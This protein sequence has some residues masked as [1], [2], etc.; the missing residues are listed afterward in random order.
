MLYSCLLFR[1][2]LCEQHDIWWFITCLYK[3][4]RCAGQR[5]PEEEIRGEGYRLI[6]DDLSSID[7]LK[8]KIIL[9]VQGTFAD[10]D[11]GIGQ[12]EPIWQKTYII[13][14]TLL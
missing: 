4:S 11:L 5:Q 6:E 7:W 13:T 8:L 12:Q 1:I 2:S 9:K 3:Q 10:L 14:S